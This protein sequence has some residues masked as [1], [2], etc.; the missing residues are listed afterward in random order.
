[1]CCGELGPNYGAALLYIVDADEMPSGAVC[2]QLRT[3]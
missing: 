1:M 3:R 2:R